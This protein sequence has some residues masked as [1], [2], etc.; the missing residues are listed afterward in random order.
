MFQLTITAKEILTKVNS[1]GKTYKDSERRGYD[2]RNKDQKR[3][4]E[5]ERKKMNVD[6]GEFWDQKRKFKKNFNGVVDEAFDDD[7]GNVVEYDDN[8]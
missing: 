1:V 6:P 8:E 7:R 5:R 3:Q 2:K 4:Q